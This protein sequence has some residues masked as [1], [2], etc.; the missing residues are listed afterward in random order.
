[1]R[2]DVRTQESRHCQHRVLVSQR[3]GGRREQLAVDDFVAVPVVG[4][5]A[6]HVSGPAGRGGHAHEMRLVRS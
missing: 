1:M 6:N 3:R 2:V 5:R 4:K